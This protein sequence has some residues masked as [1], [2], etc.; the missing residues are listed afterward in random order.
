MPARRRL[1]IVCVL[2]GLAAGVT[3]VAWRVNRLR[4]EVAQSQPASVT[5]TTA[6]AARF[7]GAGACGPCHEREFELWKGSHHQLAMQ[8]ATAASVLGDFNNAS[9]SHNGVA[10]SFFRRGGDFFVRT[11]GPDSALHDYRIAYT[12]GVAP[13]QQYLV[14]FP[15]GRLQALGIAWDSRPRG[16][17][18]QRWFHLYPGQKI[19]HGD[20]LHWTGPDQTWN[21]MCADCHSTNVRKQY[22]FGTRAYA[23][24]YAEID[25]GCEACHGPGSNHVVWARKQ[26]DSWQTGPKAK[27][28]LISLDERKDVTWL[29]DPASGNARRSVP[30]QSSREIQM[31]ARCHAR[32]GQIHEDFVH[33]QP[34][35]DDYR[36]ALLDNDLY[37]PDGQ[38]KAEDYEYGSF[39]Q[40]RMYHAGVTCSDCHEPHS[41]RLRA[42]GNAVCLQCHAR[43]KYDS[44]A[45]HFHKLGSPGARCVECHM[46]TEVYMVVDARRD[47]SIRIPRPDLSVKIGVPNA[48]SKCHTDKPAQW[49]ADAM[50]KW[51]GHAP[52]GFQNFAA[53]LSAGS[54]GAPGAARL[55]VEIAS[56]HNQPAIARASALARLGSFPGA[57]SLGAIRQNV[58]D[59]D[60]LVRRATARALADADPGEAARILGPLTRDPVRAVRI[61]AA[62]VIAGAPADAVA[63]DD[64]QALKAAV[65]EYVA[66]QELN[67]DRPEAHLD[68]ALLYTHEKQFGKAETQLQDALSLEPSF[69]PASANL[70]DL[71]R[72]LG[73]DND[74]ERVLRDAIAR[75]P[76]NASLQ[77]A[78]GLLLI[79][80]GQRQ[81]ALDLLAAAARLDPSNTRFAYAYALALDDTGQTGAAITVLEDEIKR[82][83]YDG[84]SLGTLAGLYAKAGNPRQAVVYAQRLVE[85]E[86]DNPQ[87]QQ[88]LGQLR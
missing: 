66:A 49:A 22:D 21:F 5:T 51:Y 7:V 32:R 23:T 60:S 12:F 82:H 43:G 2:T 74:G 37:Y 84:A 53:A 88:L 87:A 71:Y 69:A 52:G 36:V 75:A 64:A 41:S 45:H 72:E 18:G 67:A 34:L 76:D 65:G 86:P 11:D 4:R 70:A 62:E 33:G 57:L 58:A 17:G 31:C 81:Q 16:Q 3:L 48:C 44:P 78:M 26:P 79:R 8:P 47:H 59:S 19:A 40:S 10:S 39:I 80:K 14:R 27:G 24:S 73:R 29:S 83:P 77:H 15:G 50:I 56:D 63:A 9:F 1:L 46:P 85:L 42:E 28:L 61:E 25:V 35:G 20:P 38:I 30:R 68:L 55:L 13:L 54:L 6:A